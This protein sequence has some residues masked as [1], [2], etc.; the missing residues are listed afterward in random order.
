M[1]RLLYVLFAALLLA[2][3]AT[4]KAR[5]DRLAEGAPAF[6]LDGRIAVK[7]DGRHSSGGFHWQHAAD[8]D[9]IIML[10]PLGITIAHVRQD[11]HG[12]LLETSGKQYVAQ[13]GDELMQRALG[14]HLPLR[15]MPY[16][17]RA[18]PM[19]G[20]PANV[21]R[22]AQGQISQ[23]Q[24]DGWDIHYTAYAADTAD[25]LPLRITM[26]REQLQIRLLIDEWK[27]N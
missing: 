7:Y 17:V 1:L 16:W 27:R 14:W 2:G 15:G 23:L 20:E 22:D 12:A 6:A 24:Q 25:S 18:K 11:A 8:S 4:D 19:P 26:Q 3:C 5:I 21:T 10:A 13:D 9:D